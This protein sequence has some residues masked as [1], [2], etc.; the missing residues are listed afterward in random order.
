MKVLYDKSNNN[1]DDVDDDDYDE[2][3][4]DYD[5]E[6]DSRPPKLYLALSDTIFFMI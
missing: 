2:N 6:D 3:D 1:D 4:D 5:V